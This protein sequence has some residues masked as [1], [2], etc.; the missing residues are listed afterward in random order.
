MVCACRYSSRVFRSE[1]AKAAT[2]HA[3]QAQPTDA[4]TSAPHS[5]L[6]RQAQRL[7]FLFWS[8]TT[9]I[10]LSSTGYGQRCIG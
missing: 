1:K 3:Q 9:G 7:L 2:P 10:Q 8:G 5:M 4:E 6:S